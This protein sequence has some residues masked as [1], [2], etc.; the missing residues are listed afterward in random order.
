MASLRLATSIPHRSSMPDSATHT[1]LVELKDKLVETTKGA[2]HLAATALDV[3]ASATQNVPYLGVISKVLVE[4]LKIIDEV[5]ACKSTWKIVMAKIQTME[6]IIHDFHSQCIQEG[7]EEDELPDTIKQAFKKFEVCLLTTITTMNACKVNSRSFGDRIRLVYKRTELKAAV[8]QCS[9]DTDL[10]LK[11]FQ[12]N[13]QINLFKMVHDQSAVI[14]DLRDAVMPHI[15]PYLGALGWLIIYYSS[16]PILPPAPAIFYGHSVDVNHVVNL[17][18]EPVPAH[19]AIVGS[20][21]IG[22]TSIALTSI[23]HPNV[24]DNFL[25]QRFFLSCEA[26]FIADSLVLDL[27]K[28]FGVPVDPGG[29]RSPA[30]T[31][32]LFLQSMT[33]KCL[34]CL[35]NFETPW[36]SDRDHIEALLGR[37]AVHHLT[38]I[39]TSRDADRPRGIVW[40]DIPPIQPLTMNAAIQTWDAISHGHD[41]F[42]RLLIE[43]VDCIPLAVTLLSQLAQT[44]SSETLWDRWKTESTMLVK[45]DGSTHRLNNLDHSIELSLRGPRLHVCPGA[46]DFFIILCMLPQGMPES[47]IPAFEIAFKEHLAGIR[48]AI[49]VLKQCSLAYTLDGFLRVLSPVRQYTQSHQELSTVLSRTLFT[50]MADLYF[51]LIPNDTSYSTSREQIQLEVGNISAILDVCLTEYADVQYVLHNILAFSR[52]CR[53]LYIYDTRLLSRAAP[54]AQHHSGSLEGDC[55]REKGI[56]YHYIDNLSDAESMFKV[57]LDLHREADDKMG[58]ANDLQKVGELYQR[59]SRLEEAEQA[60]Q[61]ALD[62]HRKVDDRLGQANDLQDLGQLYMRVNR[63]EEAEQAIQSA[64]NLHRKLDDRLGQAN[65][66]QN[67]GEL[68]MRVDRLEEAEQALQS[69]LDFH[70]KVDYRLGQ[71][72]DLQDLGELYMMVDCLEEAEQALQ[73]ALDLHRKADSRLGQANDLQDL[74]RLYMWL[75]RLEESEQAL[76]S[77]LNLHRMV[78]ERLGQANDLH[79]LGELYMRIDRLKEAEKALQSALDLHRKVDCRLGQANDLNTLGQLYMRLDHLGKSEQTLQHALNLH[80]MVNERLGQAND[81]QALGTL[82]ITQRRFAQA[83]DFLT[84]AKDM[85]GHACHLRGQQQMEDLLDLLHET[86]N[87][88]VENSP[89][90]TETSAPKF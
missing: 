1:R 42:S 71:A 66:L 27:L 70:S 40:A 65:D 28:L 2:A 79:D 64:L 14:R 21:G 86:Q 41:N 9:D 72:N 19:V 3:A 76:Q 43:A 60:L 30:D 24:A 51:N 10:V 73:A 20:G 69:A 82:C 46:L 8:N 67:L 17:I 23:H 68:Y 54:I 57:A 58:E 52:V 80:R 6:M 81:L 48:S 59:L 84:G 38:L 15:P 16:A 29:S 33:S 18:L 13:L 25:H 77:A 7:R 85:Y 34:L 32:V 31:L 56:A 35:D 5:D 53:H 78:E 45:S 47:Q 26:I 89:N 49:T 63:L 4:I 55:Y 12:T 22:K 11:I 90:T 39:I 50:Q 36:E 87:V 74:G 62:L 37:I 88:Q 83:K 75:G 61:S 44:E